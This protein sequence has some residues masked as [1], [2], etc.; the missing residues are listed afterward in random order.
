[1]VLRK[2]ALGTATGRTGE[3][4]S[5]S[6]TFTTAKRATSTKIAW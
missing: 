2:V 1:M 3:R 6:T 5:V 4:W